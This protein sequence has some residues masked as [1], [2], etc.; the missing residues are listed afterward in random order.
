MFFTSLLFGYQND[1][2]KEGGKY[3]TSNNP[4]LDIHMEKNTE[5]GAMA[6]LSASAYGN[7]NVIGDGETTTGNK[8]GVYMKLNKEWFQLLSNQ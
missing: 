3:L 5:Y 4:N 1:W 2:D 6:I 7:Q 8:S